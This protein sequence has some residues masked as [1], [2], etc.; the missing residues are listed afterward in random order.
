MPTKIF[1]IFQLFHPNLTLPYSL[2]PLV[3]QL[4]YVQEQIW[5][6]AFVHAPLHINRPHKSG[7]KGTVGPQT[8]K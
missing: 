3:L 1:K 7:D 4:E 2:H 8:K 5:S 6:H